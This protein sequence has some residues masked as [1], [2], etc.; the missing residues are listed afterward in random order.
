LYRKVRRG[1]DFST[2]FDRF[3]TR[4]GPESGLFRPFPG[5]A[6][7]ISDGFVM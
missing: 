7:A 2:D 5:V 1:D 4:F 3:W 6:R